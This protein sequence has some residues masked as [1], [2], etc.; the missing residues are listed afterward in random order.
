MLEIAACWSIAHTQFTNDGDPANSNLLTVHK[1]RI[2]FL[3]PRLKGHF[4][5]ETF[6]CEEPI[7][8][9][10]LYFDTLGNA[11]ELLLVFSVSAFKTTQ[12][13]IVN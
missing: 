11:C 6:H 10:L 2:F 5:T 4:L 12:T 1:C 8:S 7:K 13:K 3:P 9:F